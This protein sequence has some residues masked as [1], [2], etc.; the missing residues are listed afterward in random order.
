MLTYRSLEHESLDSILATF[1]EGFADYSLPMHVTMD[2]FTNKI[3]EERIDL[4]LSAGMFDGDRLVG[5]ILH[6]IDQFRGQL[7]VWNGGT[8]IIPA[9][10][11]NRGVDHMYNA[12]LPAIKSRGCK[13]I[14]LEVLKDNTRA[15]RVYERIG[16]RNIRELISYKAQ[17]RPMNGAAEVR[18]DKITARAFQIPGSWKNSEVS[19]QFGPPIS[20]L[21][22]TI[23][24]GF[25]AFDGN[26]KVGTSLIRTDKNRI[27]QWAVHPDYRRR[28]IAKAM[29]NHLIPYLRDDIQV[30]NVDTLD[31]ANNSFFESMRAPGVVAQWEMIWEV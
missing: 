13:H 22:E 31:I 10:R 11:G 19:W 17:A 9:Y 24:H 25:E 7:M 27:I 8:A 2:Q 23:Y 3:R 18:I 6:A 12:L 15:H 30:V 20:S 26:Q 1:N 28:G 4:S 16:F 14:L 21:D 29:W 5:V